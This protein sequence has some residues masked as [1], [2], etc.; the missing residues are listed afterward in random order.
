M[1]VSVDQVEIAI[2]RSWCDDSHLFTR[3]QKGSVSPSELARAA[4]MAVT[5]AL[6]NGEISVSTRR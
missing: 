1:A 2:L 3:I 5:R 4:A 6:N